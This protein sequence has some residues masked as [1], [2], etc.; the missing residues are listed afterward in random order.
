MVYQFAVAFERYFIVF[1]A[2]VV[3]DFVGLTLSISADIASFETHIQLILSFVLP[4]II[5]PINSEAVDARSMMNVSNALNI[6][7]NIVSIVCLL[8]YPHKRVAVVA[9]GY[10]W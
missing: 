7:C 5:W 10:E 6:C 8:S 9:H 4:L 2:I 1:L 3:R